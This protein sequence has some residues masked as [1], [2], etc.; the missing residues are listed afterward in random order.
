MGHFIM[1]LLEAEDPAALSL[2]LE[3]LRADLKA[4][5]YFKNVPR[6]SQAGQN[7]GGVSCQDD[8]PE[9]RREV[10]KLLLRHSVK[11]YAEVRDMQAVLSY[12]RRTQWAQRTYLTTPTSF[13]TAAWHGCSEPAAPVQSCRVCYA[14]RG[15]SDRTKS[16]ADSLVLARDR[17]AKQWDKQM[18]TSIWGDHQRSRSSRQA[19]KRW[20]TCCGRCK[21]LRPAKSRFLGWS[22]AKVES[23]P[24]GGQKPTLH[25]M[26]YYSKQNRS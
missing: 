16:F 14:V 13:T 2:D 23:H 26:A 18:A 19:C 12:V 3:Q 8:L 10:F 21:T 9:V 22:G 24:R 4:D 6:F 1:G 17:F 11:F 15:S 20:T 25:R 5:P 7:G